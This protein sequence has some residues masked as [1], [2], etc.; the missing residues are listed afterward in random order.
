MEA[1]QARASIP[2]P[3]SAS[4]LESDR[5]LAAVAIHTSPASAP[6]ALSQVSPLKPT[7]TAAAAAAA[8]AAEAGTPV[9][10]AQPALR[11]ALAVSAAPAAAEA[12]VSASS[13]GPVGR[14]VG[15]DLSEIDLDELDRNTALSDGGKADADAEIAAIFPDAPKDDAPAQAADRRQTVTS[16]Q[17]ANS[18][19]APGAPSTTPES[20]PAP[21]GGPPGPGPR[22]R[23]ADNSGS[24]GGGG[25][26]LGM[27]GSGVAGT[28]GDG[29]DRRKP[30]GPTVATKV[31]GRRSTK[32]KKGKAQAAAALAAQTAAKAA[33]GVSG[34]GGGGAAGAVKRAELLEKLH[35]KRA[36]QHEL[37][38]KAKMLNQMGVTLEDIGEAAKDEADGK[39]VTSSKQEQ[40]LSKTKGVLGNV[41]KSH[42]PKQRSFLSR[43]TEDVSGMAS[44]LMKKMLAGPGR[45][46]ASGT[47]AASAKSKSKAKPKKNAKAPAPAQ[48][49]APAPAVAVASAATNAPQPSASAAVTSS[50]AAP[51]SAPGTATSASASTSIRTSDTV[52]KP[53]NGFSAALSA[54]SAASLENRNPGG[55]AVRTV[56]GVSSANKQMEEVDEADLPELDASL[57]PRLDDLVRSM[58]EKPQKKSKR[59]SQTELPLRPRV[60]RPPAPPVLTKQQIRNKRKRQ[61]VKDKLQLLKGPAPL[62]ITAGQLLTTPQ[63]ASTSSAGGS[64]SS[65]VAGSSS[66]SIGGA[67]PGGGSSSLTAARPLLSDEPPTL[68][69]ITHNPSPAAQ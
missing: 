69:P 9:S 58:H 49:Q 57:D 3:M 16:A 37:G 31:G 36:M 55:G 4:D 25:G 40:I 22:G 11:P 46:P 60:G 13:V 68:I 5:R 14:A 28:S 61:K 21:P 66:S 18:Y 8:A 1:D 56:G 47:A 35:K 50:V 2:T 53:S 41:L 43:K 33:G 23:N 6:F 7:T 42:D 59:S 38:G 48:A 27:S 65:S 67:A 63:A 32:K 15:V 24:S 51:A 26:G 64:S 17:T 10:V 52:D 12:A 34:A 29:G 20:A 30:A 54:S 44:D 62:P 19:A 39:R 45:S